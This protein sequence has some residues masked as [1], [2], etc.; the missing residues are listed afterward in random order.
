MSDAQI[1]TYEV[2][3][4]VALI[5]L[6]RPDARNAVNG[7]VA[8]G[9]E[10]AIDKMEADDNVWI[11]ADAMILPGVEIGEGSIVTARSIVSANVA[12][13]TVVAGSPARRVGVL[14]RPDEAPA[15][16]AAGEP[17]ETPQADPIAKPDAA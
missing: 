15:N 13:Y 16:A 4:K 3:G 11:G 1:V 8:S 2:T 6:N 17:S 12:P 5:T 7:D 9:L 10:A 14:P